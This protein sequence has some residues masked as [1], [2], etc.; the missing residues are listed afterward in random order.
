MGKA[1]SSKKVARAARTGGGRTRRG[2]SSLAW[3]VVM[4]L[5]VIL[6]TAGIVYSREQRSPEDT[7]P[8][9]AVAGQ[10]GDHW[11][12]ALGF[13]ICGTFAPPL[14]TATDPLGIHTH[15][16]GVVHTHPFSSRSAGT[17]A[18]L[19]LYLDTAQAKVTTDEIAIPGQIKKNGDE[20]DGKP[21]SV[22]V[23][24]WPNRDPS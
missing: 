18:R 15:D 4:G 21:A 17:N 3:P 6:G 5:V 1:S 24:V 14:S 13:D 12:S 23:K 9:A 8:R 20:C 2:A 7:P 16:D 22:Q 11:H 10:T 19:G